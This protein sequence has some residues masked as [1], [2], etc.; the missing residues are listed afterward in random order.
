[1]CALYPTVGPRDG[2][3]RWDHRTVGRWDGDG[4]VGPWDHG[5]CDHGTVG[6][7]DGGTVGPRYGGTTGQWDGW[8]TGQ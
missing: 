6:P 2:G 1:M 5:R 4:T 8:T 3:T 7:Q